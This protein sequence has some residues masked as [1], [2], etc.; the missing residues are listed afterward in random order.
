[1]T[2][3]SKSSN[4]TRVLAVTAILSAVAFVLQYFEVPVPLMPSFIKL[5]FS[6]MPALIGAFA[7]GPVCGMVTEVV[8]N[9]LHC[10]VSQ[11]FGIGEISNA[12]LGMVFTGVAGLVYR[13]HKTKKGAVTASFAG[14]A[15]MALFSFPCNLFLVYPIYYNFMPK[16]TILAAYQLILPSVTSIEQS[17]LIFNVPFTFIKGM[18][19]VVITFLIYKKIS[20]LLHKA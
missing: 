9:L 3:V 10:T 20:P 19:D 5:D 11:S 1:M 15:A 2:T 8:K 7:Y 6:D 14:A 16:E 4:R 12:L 17:L 18:I 13:N